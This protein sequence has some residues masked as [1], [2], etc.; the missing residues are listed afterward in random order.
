MEEDK[1]DRAIALTYEAAIDNAG[2]KKALL[3]IADATGS[4]S[5]SLLMYDGLEPVSGLMPMTD[6]ES[7]RTFLRNI[8]QYSSEWQSGYHVPTGQVV[9][10]DD[11]YVRENFENSLEYNE[12]W[13]TENMGLGALFVNLLVGENS[14]AVASIY[15]P[16]G[17]EYDAATR[18]QFARLAEHLKRAAEI[19]RK[20][21]LANVSDNS[22][23]NRTGY[24]VVDRQGR[25]LTDHGKALTQMANAGLAQKDGNNYRIR[26]ANRVLER[27]VA[28]TQNA[29]E[30]GNTVRLIGADAAE[31]RLDVLPADE[32]E[33]ASLSWLAI[34][35]PAAIICISAP[36]NRK[37]DRIDKL[38]SSHG[39]TPAEAA[40]AYEISIGDGRKATAHR[41]KIHETTVRSHLSAIF[42]KLNIHRQAEL[43]HIVADL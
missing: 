9:G 41:L 43:V 40:V 37:Q 17:E 42:E 38:L 1:F 39:L 3:A 34:D 20:M 29:G 33:R 19:S 36:D 10:F 12:W 16:V 13:R 27:C 4:S 24:L 21:S 15:R 2:W 26:T 31:Y 23:M 18:H 11:P 32:S 8:D 30:R 28:G 22:S 5:I 25:V 6:P 7:V 14:R 35:R